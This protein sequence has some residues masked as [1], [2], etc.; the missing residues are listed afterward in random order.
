MQYFTRNKFYNVTVNRIGWQADGLISSVSRIKFCEALGKSF[1]K[2]GAF[3]LLLLLDFKNPSS[4]YLKTRN[5]N[6]QN[7]LGITRIL[8]VLI[9]FET[10]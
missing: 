1:N 3:P 2:S 8:F 10:L 6:K 7:I 5:I 9:F 4:N